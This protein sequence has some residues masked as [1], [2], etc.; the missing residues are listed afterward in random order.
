M[1]CRAVVVSVLLLALVPAAA[2]A[3]TELN[4]IPHG[5]QE[6]GA[7]WAAGPGMLPANAQAL[8]YDRLTPLGRNITPAVMQPRADGS[9]YFKDASWVDTDNDGLID[10]PGQAAMAAV[11]DSLAGAALCGRLGAKLCKALETR[12]SRFERP[13]GGMYGGWHQYMSKDLRAL[14]GGK[15]AG[16]FHVRYCGRG[17]VER[18]ARALWAAIEKGAQAEAKRQGSTDPTRWHR[19]TATIDFTPLALARL[20]YTNRPSGI[21]QI[22][23]FAP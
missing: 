1:I 12:Q 4:V 6:P 15:V 2:S 20:Q 3:R 11:W 19:P 10:A 17:S 18:C 9:G 21:H 13:P 22:F 14:L 16:R 8:M 23:Q 7:A 5:Q